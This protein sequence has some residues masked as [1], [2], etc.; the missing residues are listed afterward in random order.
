MCVEREKGN[1][2]SKK[3]VF[4][5]GMERSERNEYLKRISSYSS[6]IPQYDVTR[7][8]LMEWNARNTVKQVKKG[9]GNGK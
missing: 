9:N 6:E 8:K 1:K 2:Q 4:K 7:R 3:G 5:M